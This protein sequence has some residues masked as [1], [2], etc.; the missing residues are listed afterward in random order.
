MTVLRVLVETTPK[1]VF[2]SALDWPGLARGGRDEASAMIALAA[3]MPRYAPVA[4]LAGQA[5][6]AVAAFEV[7]ERVEGDS[8]TAFGVPSLV[9]E[10]DRSPA[11]GAEA[12]RLARLVEAAWRTFDTVAAAAPEDL[13]KG[14]R[15]GGRDRT[16]IVEH[17]LEAEAAY[18]QVMGRRH[19]PVDAAAAAAMRADLLAVLREPSDGSPLAGKRW[20]PRYAARRIAWHALDHAWEIEDRTEPG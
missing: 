20:P 17:V 4:K 19:R 7:V 18:A 5:F 12:A 6:D 11:D 8:G 14:P 3:A 13:R 10:A 2:A 15:G 9:A 1:R 16:R